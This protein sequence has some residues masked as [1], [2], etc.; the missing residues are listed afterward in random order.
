[1]W[2]KSWQRANTV[3]FEG[4]EMTH[5]VISLFGRA[6]LA[7]I[8]VMAGF[9]KITGYSGT[10]GYME[11]VGLPGMLLPLVIALELGGGLALIAGFLTKPIA[12]ALALFSVVSAFIFHANF[13]DQMQSIMFMKNIGLAGGLLLL[14]ANGPG[15]ISVDSKLAA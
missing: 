2:F 1:M 15:E 10:V 9:G 4:F 5:S 7:M 6:A 3:E 12:A 13:G 8:F 11:S 14:V